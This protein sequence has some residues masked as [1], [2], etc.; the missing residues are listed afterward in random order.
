MIWRWLGV[1]LVLHLLAAVFSEGYYHWDEHFQIYEFLGYK[2]G[3][4]P[5]ADLPIEFAEKIRPWLQIWILWVITQFM[6][7]IRIQ[8]PFQWAFAF[9]LI[10]AIL[11]WFSIVVLAQCTPLWI[12]NVRWQKTALIGLATFWYLPALHARVSSENWGG[13]VFWIG[14]GLYFLTQKSFRSRLGIGILFGLAFEFRYQMGIM[15]AGFW[16]WLLFF[17]TTRLSK[18]IGEIVTMAAGMCLIVACGIYVNHWGYG[19]W[20]FSPWNYIR[21]N[22]VE[23]KVNAIDIFPWWDFFRRAFT[24]T[25]PLLGGILFLLFPIAWIKNLKHVL[26]WTNVP[27]F[28]IHCMIG[29][30]ELRFIFPIAS[31]GPLLFSEALYPIRFFHISRI[32]ILLKKAVVIFNWIALAGTTLVPAW[33]PVWFYKYIYHHPPASLY[34]LENEPPYKVIGIPIHYY[35]PKNLNLISIEKYEKLS[36]VFKQSQPPIWVFHNGFYLNA[37]AEILRKHCIVEYSMLPDSLLSLESTGLLKRMNNWK[38]LRCESKE[39]P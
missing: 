18:K 15:I 10:S 20:T 29:H 3:I 5:T 36:T 25:W 39:S 31:V 12:K 9:R 32:G 28:L 11:G 27:F 35:R 4:T 14:L 1:S 19:E 26:T 13:S 22:L 21:F 8:D 17:D 23:G 7:L 2:L 37:D 34:Y 6:K 30:K 24:E 38:L 16:A 33:V